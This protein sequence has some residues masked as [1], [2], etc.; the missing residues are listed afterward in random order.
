MCEYCNL[1]L[2]GIREILR[3][4]LE[5]N[6]LIRCSNMLIFKVVLHVCN[7]L[8]LDSPVFLLPLDDE[9]YQRK[10]RDQ[11]TKRKVSF[12]LLFSF[13]FFLWFSFRET[14]FVGAPLST[15]DMIHSQ[16]LNSA[17]AQACT[18]GTRFPELE[19][20]RRRRF[21]FFEKVASRT[22]SESKKA[23][24]LPA[25]LG[26]GAFDF[27]YESFAAEGALAT[28]D[29]I[30]AIVKAACLEQ[31]G[32]DSNPEGNIAQVLETRF[33]TADLLVWLKKFLKLNEQAYLDEVSRS[34]LDHKAVNEHSHL[35][36]FTLY[37]G[38][39]VYKERKEIVKDF[40]AGVELFGRSPRIPGIRNEK[41]V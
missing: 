34:G 31:L 24:K 32:C 27:V 36:Q 10:R 19:S 39:N 38:A 23:C 17:C 8:F 1:H 26:G 3:L 2:F 41:F 40:V 29:A 20:L 16:R 11:K 5:C 13:H 18:A 15:D 12:P 33:G 22:I 7:V 9:K 30:Y 4:V 14:S 21:F 25:L 37:R 35:A 6:N 28:E